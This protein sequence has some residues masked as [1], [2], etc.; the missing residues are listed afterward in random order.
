MILNLPSI[1]A[2]PQLDDFF[3]M[4]VE[5]KKTGDVLPCD[6]VEISTNYS[7]GVPQSPVDSNAFVGDTIYTNPY[8][9]SV[10]VWVYESSKMKFENAIKDA[11]FDSGFIVFGIDEIYNNL[12]LKSYNFFENAEVQGGYFYTLE[13]VE[14]ITVNAGLVAMPINLTKNKADASTIDKGVKTVKRKEKTALKGLL[15]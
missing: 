15:S 4:K 6:V 7:Y 13:F 12:R 14:V 2:L 1:T 8:I 3:I 10:R 9:I 5:N 11:Q